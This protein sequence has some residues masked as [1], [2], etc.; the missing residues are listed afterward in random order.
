[1]TNLRSDF[2][3]EPEASNDL[4]EHVD[5]QAAKRTFDEVQDSVSAET[6]DARRVLSDDIKSR[7]KTKGD[8][9]KPLDD[10]G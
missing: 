2:P 5:D 4:A 8:E 7:M 1:M 6:E 3:D 10:E 9:E